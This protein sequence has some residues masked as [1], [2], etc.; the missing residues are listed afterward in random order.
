[1]DFRL[2][3]L[4]YPEQADCH[5]LKRVRS[6]VSCVTGIWDPEQV[7]SAFEEAVHGFIVRE[8]SALD[9]DADS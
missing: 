2:F 7:W 3:L 4:L 1:M 6:C 9:P 8:K 5:D